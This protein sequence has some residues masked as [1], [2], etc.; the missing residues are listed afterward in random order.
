MQ[1]TILNK[2]TDA[3]RMPKPPWIPDRSVAKPVIDR[4]IYVQALLKDPP[5]LKSEAEKK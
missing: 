1:V 4:E 3:P 5:I 2:F